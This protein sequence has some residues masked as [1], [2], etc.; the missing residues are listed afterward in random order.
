MNLKTKS[1]M[2]LLST[3]LLFSCKNR[4][5]GPDQSQ[6][7]SLLDPHRL[8]ERGPWFEGWY[9]RI[10]PA[11]TKQ[12][13]F[14]VIVGSYLPRGELRREAEANGLTG[15]VSI[16]DG[17]KKD[18]PLRSYEA[19]PKS[20]RMYLNR[21]DTVDRDPAPKTEASFRWVAEGIGELTERSVQLA[22]PQ[23]ASISVR[24]SEVLPWNESGLGPEGYISLFRAF[25]LH[26][27][28]YSL[29]SKAEYKVVLPSADGSPAET[30]NGVGY[31]HY[32]KNWGVS[33]PPAY[34]W[35]Q[36]YDEQ[37][38]RAI[39]IAGGRPVQ[40]GPAKPEAWLVGFRSAKTSVDFAPQNIG[41][42]FQSEVDACQGRFQ[43]T[44]SFLNKR[45]RVL[46][47]APRNTFGGIAIPNETGFVKDGSE[48]SFQ[49]RIVAKLYEVMP[50]S[51][52]GGG[53]RLLEE[54]VF[55]NGALEF[56]SE[57]KCRK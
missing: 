29:K 13:S 23:S 45:L 4:S 27:F 8:P 22:L 50:F 31:A 1:L 35:M 15:Y 34:V 17:G 7:D 43:L 26:W 10:T 24:L 33:F 37:Q 21:T 44:S 11:D 14:G 12:R 9:L 16:I 55:T 48:Q 40:I 38:K 51:P 18:S 53:E 32:E 2:A 49:T 56:G 19:F 36:G 52:T 47:E 6:P 42:V 20:T 39:A 25:P 5:F 57:F 3:V 41:T 30:V 28:V 54:A 46:A